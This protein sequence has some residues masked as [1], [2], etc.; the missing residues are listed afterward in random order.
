[1]HDFLYAIRWKDT[2]LWRKYAFWDPKRFAFF[3]F[4]WPFFDFLLQYNRSSSF[5]LLCFL[6]NEQ[7]KGECFVEID[8]AG[9][10]NEFLDEATLVCAFCNW[11][12]C[13]WVPHFLNFVIS[14]VFFNQTLPLFSRSHPQVIIK[15][16]ITMIFTLCTVHRIVFQCY[17]FELT[18]VVCN[19]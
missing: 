6:Q 17:T 2:Y 7:E 3:S 1:M 11:G 4:S 9:N 16:Y 12:S 14:A 10:N 13:L 15:K 18:V 5:H 19:S 8:T